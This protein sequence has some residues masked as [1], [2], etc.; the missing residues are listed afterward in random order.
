MIDINFTTLVG[1]GSF[2]SILSPFDQPNI[3]I[4]IPHEDY[5]P[6][7]DLHYLK[8]LF[9]VEVNILNYLAGHDSRMDIGKHVGSENSVLLPIGYVDVG[10]HGAPRWNITYPVF[11]RGA[12]D[13]VDFLNDLRQTSN[14]DPEAILKRIATTLFTAMRF[15]HHYKVIHMDIKPDN[16]IIFNDGTVMLNDFGLARLSN[17][18]GT[19][20]GTYGT[21]DYMA[22]EVYYNNFYRGD[23]ADV[24]SAGITI[25]RVATFLGMD[26]TRLHP[27]I[28]NMVSHNPFARPPSSTLY[29]I[30]VNQETP[31]TLTSVRDPDPCHRLDHGHN[32]MVRTLSV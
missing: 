32:M 5:F 8:D 19:D 9:I 23:L 4:K 26:I 22:P 2:A 24:Y 16:L 3:V 29:K 7:Y 21:G 17:M 20:H 31:L 14:H 1:K 12:C 28:H 13:L 25:R 18:N 27:D 6:L 15:M 30:F 10:G 11:R